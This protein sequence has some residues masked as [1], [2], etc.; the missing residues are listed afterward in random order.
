M[1]GVDQLVDTI[2]GNIVP[3]PLKVLSH[4]SALVE[5]EKEFCATNALLG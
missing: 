2:Q 3:Y 4:L 5:V 1:H